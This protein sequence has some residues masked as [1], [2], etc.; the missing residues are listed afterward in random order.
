MLV[1]SGAVRVSR[2]ISRNRKALWRMSILARKKCLHNG[3][4]VSIFEWMTSCHAL[5]SEMTSEIKKSCD[6]NMSRCRKKHLE[7]W[8]TSEDVPNWVC[9]W[10]TEMKEVLFFFFAFMLFK[11]KHAWYRY[12][13]LTWKILS[14]CFETNS[15]KTRLQQFWQ[16]NC[17]IQLGQTFAIYRFRSEG[18]EA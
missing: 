5:P 13:V 16:S 2:V 11:M 18:S 14:L 8:M 7:I 3:Y 15:R 10:L 9:V 17:L 4:D 12:V 1:T 6:K